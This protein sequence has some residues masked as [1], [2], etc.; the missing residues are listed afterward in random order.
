MTTE[1]QLI[2]VDEQDN[3]LG[4]AGK[5]S[6]HQQGLMHRAFSVFIFRECHGQTEL[7]LQQRQLDKYHCGGLWT[8]TCCSHPRPGELTIAAGQRRLQEEMG[9]SSELE[10]A[11][12]FHY[13]AHFNNGLTENEVDHV[14]VGCYAGQ[15]IL[16]NDQEVHAYRWVEISN[17]QN[18]LAENEEL[19]TPWFAQA[20]TIALS[21]GAE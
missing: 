8:N 2:L 10:E 3:E 4:V 13:I 12:V 14:L 16:P 21:K 11:G 19:F 20:L 7:L 5:L 17:L 18:Q 6:A 15:A 9:F 1:E